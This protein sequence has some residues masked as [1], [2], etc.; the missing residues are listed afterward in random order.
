VR[1]LA[2]RLRI[3]GEMSHYEEDIDDKFSFFEG[4]SERLF[5]LAFLINTAGSSYSV[6][7]LKEEDYRRYLSLK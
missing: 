4:F 3:Y 2:D 6:Y 7:Q 1:I 5:V